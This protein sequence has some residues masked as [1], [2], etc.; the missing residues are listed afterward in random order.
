MGE[1]QLGGSILATL[2][3]VLRL[4]TAIYRFLSIKRPKVIFD[5]FVDLC[6]FGWFSGSF[7][8]L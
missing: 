7:G 1:G 4:I 5:I 6:V 3:W 8:R 2:M